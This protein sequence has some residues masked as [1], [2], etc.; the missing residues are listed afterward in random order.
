MIRPYGSNQLSRWVPVPPVP[1]RK[2]ILRD[3]HEALGHVGRDKLVESTMTQWWW[4]KIRE[5]AAAAVRSCP[6][7]A[8][9]SIPKNPHTTMP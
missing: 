5:D 7:C 6:A 2:Q 8:R 4:E 9:D 3:N 1:M